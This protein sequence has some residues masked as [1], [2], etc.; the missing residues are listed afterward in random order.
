VSSIVRKLPTKQRVQ[1]I[2]A[3]QRLADDR[4]GWTARTKQLIDQHIADIGD[5]ITTAE[6]VLVRRASVLAVELERLELRFAMTD[7]P[8]SAD[9]DL[10]QKLTNT[11]RRTLQAL[12]HRRAKTVNAPTLQ[13]YLSNGRRRLEAAE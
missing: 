11:L 3:L 4:V 1:A 13:D 8:K 5:D 12:P 9:L 2:A 10:Y 7:A 6:R